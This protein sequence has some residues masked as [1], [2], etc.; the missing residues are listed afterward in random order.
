MYAVKTLL[1]LRV[2]WGFR[3]PL[4]VEKMLLV[5]ANFMFCSRRARKV[6]KSCKVSVYAEFLCPIYAKSCS[7]THMNTVLLLC[8]QPKLLCIFSLV[9]QSLSKSI[10]DFF[11]ETDVSPGPQFL[12]GKRERRKKTDSP[13]SPTSPFYASFNFNN[14]PSFPPE[15]SKGGR[16]KE[17]EEG[18]V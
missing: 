13:P 12:A 14:H 18:G 16:E 1:L 2:D 11:H 4:C 7:P 17:E 9:L 5:F 15:C 6:R 3:F 8:I 10:I